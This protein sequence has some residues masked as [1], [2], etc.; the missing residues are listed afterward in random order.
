MSLSKTVNRPDIALIVD[1]DVTN[2][3]KRTKLFFYVLSY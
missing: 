1:W 3:H 2:Q